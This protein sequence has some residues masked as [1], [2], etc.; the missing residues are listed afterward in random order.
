MAPLPMDR[1]PPPSPHQARIL[2]LQENDA[3]G[4]VNAMIDELRHGLRERGWDGLQ[5]EAL[6][7]TSPAALVR[8]AWGCDAILATNNFRTAYVG[9]A[10]AQLRRRPCLVWVHGPLQEVLAQAPV[11]PARQAALRWLYRRLPAYVFNSAHTRQSFEAFIGRAVPSG[12]GWVIANAVR[13]HAAPFSAS[14]AAYEG[15]TLELGYV[16][17][18]APEK[19]PQHLIAMLRF[20]PPAYR[21]TLVGDGPLR[22]ALEAE[23][24]DLCAA[25]R[26]VFA[27]ERPRRQAID[28]AW[29]LTVLASRYEGGCPLS[30]LESAA[31]GI[32]F[33]APP[34]PAVQETVCGAAAPLLAAD[35]SPAALAQAV[36]RVLGLPTAEV[37]AALNAVL[38]AH[39]PARFAQQWSD[40]LSQVLARP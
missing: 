25:G 19:A 24:A 18:L 40:A 11:A 6:N 20:L 17:R 7:R 12:R 9:W 10:L 8:A 32:P 31:A 29:R 36:V 5:V 15:S 26:L 4:G 33:I 30:A 22:A 37:Q 38:S 2:L 27:G 21:L 3:T 1:T 23:G 34:L 39:D 14:S 35:D 28:P 13:P 16:G